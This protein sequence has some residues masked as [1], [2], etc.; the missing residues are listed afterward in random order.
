MPYPHPP[1]LLANQERLWTFDLYKSQVRGRYNCIRDIR[2]NHHWPFCSAGMNTC[3]QPFD[4]KKLPCQDFVCLSVF[5][6]GGSLI[7][8][9]IL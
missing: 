6:T 4:Q 7:P 9:V 8:I 5:S 2:R 3:L 1:S